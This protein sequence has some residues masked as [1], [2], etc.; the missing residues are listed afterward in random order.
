MKTLVAAALILIIGL[1][2]F[3]FSLWKGLTNT[4][5]ELASI[6]TEFLNLQ[7]KRQE[8]DRRNRSLLNMSVYSVGQMTKSPNELNTDGLAFLEMRLFPIHYVL[9]RYPLKSDFWSHGGALAVNGMTLRDNVA[10][11]RQLVDQSKDPSFS[12]YSTSARLLKHVHKRLQSNP[13]H[14]Q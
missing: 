9:A 14:H 7:L 13:I 3:S 1:M 4:Q 8:E 2:C 11:S 6:K 5:N 10:N 12:D